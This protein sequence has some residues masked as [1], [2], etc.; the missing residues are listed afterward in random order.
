MI[1]R[2]FKTDNASMKPLVEDLKK[3]LE[4]NHSKEYALIQQRINDHYTDKDGNIKKGALEEYINVFSDLISKQKIDLSDAG[5][6][7]LRNKFDSVLLG[8]GLQD[9]K[10]ETAQDLVRFIKNYNTNIN[11]Q[12]LLGK[13]MGSKILDARIE[14]S[15]LQKL[16]KAEK[17]EK[18]EESETSV[19]KS[20]SPEARQQISDSVQ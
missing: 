6:S 10:I 13:L 12:G 8:F 1:S 2:Q 14:S 18:A 15:K 5:T 19:K 17:S 16:D 3:Y 11:R 20:M 7:S 4:K 9:V